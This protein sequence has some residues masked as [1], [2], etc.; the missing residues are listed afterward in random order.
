MAEIEL[1]RD[2]VEAELR[3]ALKDV[4]GCAREVLSSVHQPNPS[5]PTRWD[6]APGQ[7]VR[8]CNAIEC[9]E[10]D[11]DQASTIL[12]EADTRA[13]LAHTGKPTVKPQ[14]CATEGCDH[15]ATVY[16]ERGGVGSHYCH[17]CY[18]RVQ[19]IQTGGET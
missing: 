13:A 3:Q 4:L 6:V 18:M 1:D 8:F 7:H 5:D 9:L 17:N 16:F 2:A 19:A 10:A 11:V 15:S 12:D 14:E